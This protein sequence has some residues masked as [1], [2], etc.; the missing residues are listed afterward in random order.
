M[1]SVS[2]VPGKFSKL[3]VWF[4]QAGVDTVSGHHDPPPQKELPRTKKQLLDSKEMAGV[5]ECRILHKI[6]RICTVRYYNWLYIE[7]IL[8]I[9]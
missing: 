4:G 3:Y 9:E 7:I 5:C 6:H 2:R 1:K 8:L